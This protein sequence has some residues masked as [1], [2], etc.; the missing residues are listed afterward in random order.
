MSFTS[1]GNDN[2][3]QYDFRYEQ[4]GSEEVTSA[5][6]PETVCGKVVN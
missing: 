5:P 1:I 2:E 3:E 6:R 4:D